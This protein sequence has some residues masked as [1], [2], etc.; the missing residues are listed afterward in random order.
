[1]SAPDY[2]QPITG[3][4]TWLVA[5]VDGKPRLASVFYYALWPVRRELVS[6]C[7][8]RRSRSRLLNRRAD[9]E[10]HS[11]PGERCACGIYAA[12]ELRTALGYL[13]SSGL[14]DVREVEG[15]AVLHR[16]LGRVVLWGRLVECEAGWRGA[17]AYPQCLYLP[18]RTRRGDPVRR[19]EDVALSLTEYGVPV[20]ILD[21]AGSEE[22]ITEALRELLA[23]A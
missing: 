22:E 6:E 1:V 16:V 19:L 15:R 9:D 8:A 10:G 23:A 14:R 3:W 7:L 20:Q 4:R 13:H 11:T 21:G 17:F 2:V 18:E 12:R 5:D